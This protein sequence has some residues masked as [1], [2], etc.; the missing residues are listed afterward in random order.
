MDILR[1]EGE[2]IYLKDFRGAEKICEGEIKEISLFTH[3][4]AL[5]E[6]TVIEKPFI[7]FSREDPYALDGIQLR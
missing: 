5:R 7:L 6:L 2:R 4:I 3:R 1:P